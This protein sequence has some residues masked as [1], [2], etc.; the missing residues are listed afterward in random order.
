MARVQEQYDSNSNV[1]NH[2]KE[3]LSYLTDM[4]DFIAYITPDLAF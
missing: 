2:S 3:L 4:T 1:R